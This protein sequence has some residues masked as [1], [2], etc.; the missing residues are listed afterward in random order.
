MRRS[1]SGPWRALGLL[2]MAAAL[3]A[4][5]PAPLTLERALERARAQQPTVLQAQAQ[6]QQAQAQAEQAR[7]GL[8][9][10]LNGTAGYSRSTANFVA[11]PGQVPSQ[12]LATRTSSLNSYG[13]YS[14]GLN[15]NQLIYDFGQTPAVWGSARAQAQ[16]KTLTA[17]ATLVTVLYNVRSAY[18]AALAARDVAAVAVQALANQERHLQQIEGF[19]RVGL[20]PDIDLLQVRSERANAR[21]Q[22]IATD[23]DYATKRA[24]LDQAMG[25]TGDPDAAL[26]DASM[27]PIVEEAA[28]LEV[29]V[30]EALAT[31]P[32][33]AAL[34]AQ[35]ASQ[36]LTVRAAQRNFLPNLAASAGLTDAG[37]ELDRLTWNWSAG[38]SLTWPL[39]S[40][41]ASLAQLHQAE[42]LL[43]GLEAQR[44]G[45]TQSVHV[46]VLQARLA[47][48]AGLG[49]LVAAEES[50]DNA[51]ARLR[52]A[53]GRYAAQVGNIIELEDAQLARGQA[54]VQAV[55][56]TYGLAT[57]RAQLLSALG[58]E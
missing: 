44:Q 5:A 29:L 17:R 56:A 4:A 20:R 42:A 30:Q 12:F 16:A 18:F 11:R 37:R 6:A 55:Q 15:A 14:L 58:R 49:T 34:E 48:Q 25:W 40:G 9:P 8:L 53:M 19:V 31:Q 52:L 21:V 50:R 7:A 10:G 13:Y 24:L 28:A 23:N 43:R 2:A 36:T 41:G 54:A 38:I 27:A 35:V 26:A 39:F 51:D 33:Y 57:A 3:A 32:A 1:L 45:L 47:V 22:R 46:A